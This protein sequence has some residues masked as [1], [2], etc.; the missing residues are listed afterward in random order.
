MS[1]KIYKLNAEGL[2]NL[3]N[4]F[5]MVLRD[6]DLLADKRLQTMENKHFHGNFEMKTSPH[7]HIDARHSARGRDEEYHFASHEMEE[8]FAHV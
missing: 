1:M 2:F 8:I 3:K 6:A 4:W 7:I 5:H